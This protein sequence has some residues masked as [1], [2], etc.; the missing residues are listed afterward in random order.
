MQICSVLYE[1]TLLARITM[2]KTDIKRSRICTYATS[3]LEEW[4]YES[5]HIQAGVILPIWKK[6]CSGCNSSLLLI[7]S[8]VP[9]RVGEVMSRKKVKFPAIAKP[10]WNFTKTAI[11]SSAVKMLIIYRNICS[12]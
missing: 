3:Q 9:V 11:G 4:C 7:T 8:G 5:T 12:L 2:L 1:R 6:I 10:L